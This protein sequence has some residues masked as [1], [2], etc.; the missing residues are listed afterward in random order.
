MTTTD[1]STGPSADA[2][3]QIAMVLDLNKCIGCQTCSVAC[4]TLWGSDEGAD[5]QWWCSVN[6]MPGAGTPKG[7]EQMGGG[8][9]DGKP[10]KG[11]APARSDFGGGWKY[12]QD[13]IF[14]GGNPDHN[15]LRVVGETPTWGPNWDEDQG[16]GAY[17]NSFFYYLPRLCNFCTH[18]AC[19]EACPK[20]AMAKRRS[21]GVVV[22]DEGR[23]RGYRYCAEACPY[24]KI[25]FNYERKVSQHCIGCLPRLEQGVA[26]ACARMC[27]GRLVFVG[28]LDD[29][30]GPI[31]KLVNQW[32]VA[33]PLHPEYETL[34]N[35]YYIPPL[36]PA[37][38][39]EDG[40]L[41]EFSLR[42]PAEQLEAQFGKGVHQA[43]ATL[44]DEMQRTRSGESSELMD[45]LI[46]YGWQELFPDFTR[47]PVDIQWNS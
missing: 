23:C 34:P 11:V 26:P 16:G 43:L 9:R 5:Y 47:D 25:Y 21:D 42:I 29:P 14:Y 44:V 3:R 22:R 12:N 8:F 13:E 7:Y 32:K 24:K 28:Y 1:T 2:G 46:V 30:D 40:S 36:G 37:P 33:L 35:V 19:V 41:D 38:Y 31:H 18:P 6:T 27:P 4:K 17:P 45:M 10:V 39:A 20:G 15:P